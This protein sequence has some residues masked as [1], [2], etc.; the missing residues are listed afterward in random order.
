MGILQVEFWAV[1]E[2]LEIQLVQL[3]KFQHLAHVQ[4]VKGYKTN[5]VCIKGGL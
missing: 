5:K 4:T 1:T 2:E 3:V